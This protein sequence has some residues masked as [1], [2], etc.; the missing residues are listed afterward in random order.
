VL[1]CVGETFPGRVAASLLKA[2][3]L[4]ELIAESRKE[5]MEMAIQLA[6]DPQRLK[7]IR[8]R[9]AENRLTTPLFDSTLFTKHIEAGYQ[10]AYDRYHDGLSPDHIF[11]EQ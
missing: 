9:L 7:S 10:K 5:Y 8:N 3:G 1:T 6:N 11:V 2:I 4:P